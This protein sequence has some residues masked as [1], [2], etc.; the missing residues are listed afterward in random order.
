MVL[1]LKSYQHEEVVLQKSKWMEMLCTSM[2]CSTTLHIE[3]GVIL[4]I[5]TIW[6][7]EFPALHTDYVLAGLANL[8]VQLIERLPS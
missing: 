3:V 1:A 2:N 6:N 4:E 5:L 8:W 7:N